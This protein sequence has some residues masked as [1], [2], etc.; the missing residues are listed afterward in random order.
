MKNNI[1]ITFSLLLML[2]SCDSKKEKSLKIGF[3]QCTTGDSWRKNML[4]GMKRELSF[5]P[6]IVFEMKDSEGKTEKQNQ[7][8][9]KFID[10]KVD[11][12]IVSPNENK[13]HTEVIEKAYN[14]GIPVII[15]DRRTTSNKYTAFVGAENYLVGQNAGEYANILLKGKGTV[16]DI[17]ER[18][19]SSSTID[20]NAGFVNAIKKYPNIKFSE[21]LLLS[22]FD[23]IRMKKYFI[24]HPA[25]NLVFAHNDRIAL[26]IYRA[27][28]A[29]GIS[30]KIK[31]IGVDGLA[32]TNEGLDMVS[33]GMIDATILYPT[34]GEESIQTAVKILEKQPFD[35][36]NQLFTTVI[37]P[38]NV[39]I[40]LSQFQKIKVQQQDIERQALKI[41]D[42]NYTYSSQRNRL[43]FI[44]ALLLI[45]IIL[46]GF[47]WF[48]LIEKQN[49][50]KILEDQNLA[51]IKQNEEIERVSLQARQAVEDKMRFYSYISHEFKTPLS[52]ILTPT[53]DLLNRK[54]YD[55]KEGKPVLAL[56][57]KNANRLLRLVDQI[58]DFRKIDAGKIVLNTETYDLVSFTKEIVN[59]FAI[60]AK[61]SNIDLQF[62]CPFKE[63]S[64]TFD[65]EKLDKVFF[66]IISNAFKYTPNGGLIH[67]MLLRNIQNIEISITDNGVGMDK[68]DKENAFELFYRA[69]QNISF[70]TG[71]GLALSREFVNLHDG[72]INIESE[73]GKGTT[74]KIVLPYLEKST[75]IQKQPIRS[76]NHTI[77]NDT[78]LI[79]GQ[80]NQHKN[81]KS[82][83]EI[84]I[85]IVEDNL[86]LLQFL[87]DK[88]S[89]F[90]QVRTAESAES[91]WEIILNTIPDVIISDVTLPGRDGFSLTQQIKEDFRTS[92]IPVILLTARGKLESQIEG[93]KAGADAYMGKPFNQQLLEEKLKNLLDN[94]DRIR[95]RFSNEITNLSHVQSNERKFL[96]DFELLIE[97]Y[98]KENTLSV[99]HLSKEMGMS[100]VQLYRKI[101][102]LTNKN[103]NDYIAEYKIKKAKQ[104]LQDPTKNITEIA[105][106]L[107][108][109]NPGYFTTFFKQKTN[110]TPSDWRNM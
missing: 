34:G 62:I 71:L 59:D 49:S 86:D 79:N 101:T 20:R 85:V 14:A 70:G 74:F 103:V 63:L 89:Q 2:I 43:Y 76:I 108:F 67:I 24:E 37:T 61:K 78:F 102:A 28:K 97:K 99:E 81:I 15:L 26:S 82:E 69:S 83:S 105:Y 100:R 88:F 6:E 93:E 106:E 73:K 47:L 68:K 16:L 9:Q 57:L 90:Y 36:E 5:Y 27:S 46:G 30:K 3:S 45:V 91:G 10:E 32:G 40:M 23:S 75:L 22:N 42:L 54:S 48:L 64:Y 65:A 110:Q 39:R 51:I 29:L 87:S 33:K 13:V 95:R 96:I 53:E 55:S 92:H 1:S 98:M 58:L 25:V 7:D 44:S 56:I 38:D 66:N 4:D 84:S 60:K 12:L 19:N 8:I 18:S 17:T 109:N 72:E 77:E 80:I 21:S 50:N 107:G 35:K 52:L 94:R 11:L 31:I 41:T 104:L